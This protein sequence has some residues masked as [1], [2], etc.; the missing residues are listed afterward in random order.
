MLYQ[1]MTKLNVTPTTS[2]NNKEENTP[3][4]KNDTICHVDNAEAIRVARHVTWVGF[5]WNAVL[6]T[7]KVLGGIFG[8]SNALLADGIHS[9]SDFLSDI[10]VLVMVGIA[11]RKPNERYQYGHGKYETFATLMLAVVLFV[12]A[13]GIFFG[14]AHNIV[15]ALNGETLPRPGAIALVLCLASLLVK[16]W[17]Y[18]YTRKAGERINSAAVVANAWHHRSD[19]FSSVATLLG[20]AGAMFLG[21]KGLILDPIAAMIV[22]VMIVV[23]AVKMALPAI[24]ELLEAALPKEVEDEIRT[25]IAE[26][27]GVKAY[28]H[29]RARRNGSSVIVEVHIKVNPDITVTRAHKI[30]TAVEQNI[31]SKFCKETTIV[32]THIEPYE[33]EAV[34]PDGS[35]EERS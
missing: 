6:G 24:R 34:A 25:A 1:I 2:M 21:E 5:W 28:H 30:A 29:L 4:R 20:V 22:A 35:C 23:V 19:A 17:L 8:R 18:R 11:R 33:G 27:P 7:A 13:A 16:E 26:T 31:S 9:F 12:V 15:D 32:T 10:I 14:G 3:K